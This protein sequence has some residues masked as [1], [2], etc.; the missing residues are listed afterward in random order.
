MDADEEKPTT[1][2]EETKRKFREAIER[3]QQQ[4]SNRTGV[5]GAD[6]GIRGARGRAGGKREFRRKSG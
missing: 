4:A 1:P 2:S 6:S 5:P 3:K